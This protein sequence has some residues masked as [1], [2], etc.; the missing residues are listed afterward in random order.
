[1]A[2]NEKAGG[3]AGEKGG[4]GG[5]RFQLREAKRAPVEGGHQPP[6]IGG[7]GEAV[8]YSG[9]VGGSKKKRLLRSVG[10]G[11]ATYIL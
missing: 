11:K 3:E 8:G 4:S 10:K 2:A 9:G 7:E 6:A 1:V 5:K